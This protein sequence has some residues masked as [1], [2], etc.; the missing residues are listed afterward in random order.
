MGGKRDGKVAG[1]EARRAAKEAAFGELS[2]RGKRVTHSTG[3][4]WIESM[5][6]SP[7]STLV[8][9]TIQSPG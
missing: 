7:A 6:F 8:T 4:I 5:I 1:H 3:R 2:S 9:T